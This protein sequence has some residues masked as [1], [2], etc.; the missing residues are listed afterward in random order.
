MKASEVCSDHLAQS[1]EQVQT[2]QNS[3]EDA[4]ICL[5]FAAMQGNLL[6]SITIAAN[7]PFSVVF[8]LRTRRFPLAF[9]APVNQ[10]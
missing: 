9:S 3:D 5:R 2:D 1:R 10:K 4:A 7:I 6:L 8:I